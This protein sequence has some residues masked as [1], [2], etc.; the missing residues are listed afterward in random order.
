MKKL[1]S[2]FARA[3]REAEMSVKRAE[4]LVVT[5]ANARWH[6]NEEDHLAHAHADMHHAAH[7]VA[8]PTYSVEYEQSVQCLWA[9]R[10]DV[11][12][13]INLEKAIEHVEK[14]IYDCDEIDIPLEKWPELFDRLVTKH[15]VSALEVARRAGTDRED[16]RYLG[17][18]WQLRD[19]VVTG[20][21][22]NKDRFTKCSRYIGISA[23]KLAKQ[24]ATNDKDRAEAKQILKH[25][26]QRSEPFPVGL[27]R[28]L[29]WHPPSNPTNG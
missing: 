12:S 17:V 7:E 14:V 28:A 10:I 21:L 5:I 4:T 29:F 11:L 15:P 3:E 9:K 6:D 24:Y 25:L 27:I 26:H 22:K 23:A 18:N 8:G 2:D 20:L 1:L 16:E 19:L 13:E